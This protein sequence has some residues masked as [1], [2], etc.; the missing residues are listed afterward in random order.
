MDEPLEDAAD[1][2]THI[3]TL[4]Y[5]TTP[6][7]DMRRIEIKETIEDMLSK[8][9]RIQEE[10]IRKRFGIGYE[11]HRLK[12][13]GDEKG[14]SR[15]WIRQIEESALKKLRQHYKGKELSDFL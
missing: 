10:V 15:E 8:L 13:I 12:D 14:F 4:I 1:S 5:E 9:T 3:D 6:E 2:R 7:D 11:K